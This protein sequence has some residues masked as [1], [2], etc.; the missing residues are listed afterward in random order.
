MH[1]T[2]PRVPE[3]KKKRPA[4]ASSRIVGLV[5]HFHEIVDVPA[6]Q[7]SHDVLAWCGTTSK[8]VSGRWVCACVHS[9][10]LFRLHLI[11]IVLTVLSGLL[12]RVGARLRLRRIRIG[13]FCGKDGAGARRRHCWPDGSCGRQTVRAR[14]ELQLQRGS[15]A[16]QKEDDQQPHRR[17]S[18]RTLEHTEKV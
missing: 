1:V 2:M 7:P 18:W 14:M 12:L 6:Q 8:A 3:T 10:A 16:G 17:M 9:P 5:H 4:H 13:V 15:T 11:L